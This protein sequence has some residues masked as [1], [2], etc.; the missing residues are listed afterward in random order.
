MKGKLLLQFLS[1]R[2]FGTLGHSYYICLFLLIARKQA[3][4]CQKEQK[5]CDFTLHWIGFRVKEYAVS[6]KKEK[7]RPAAGHSRIDGSVA[8]EDILHEG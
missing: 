5:G 8:V 3:Q 7:R 1:P 2:V 4:D 6:S